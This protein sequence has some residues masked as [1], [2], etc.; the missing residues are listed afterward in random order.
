MADVQT[1]Q[2]ESSSHRNIGLQET[3]IVIIKKTLKFILLIYFLIL[4][5]LF[6]IP[7]NN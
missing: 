7:C 6:V 1:G 2:I 3:Y 4:L 5:T